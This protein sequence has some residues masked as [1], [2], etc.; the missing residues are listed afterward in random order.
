MAGGEI[1]GGGCLSFSCTTVP[2]RTALSW[3]HPAP[4]TPPS[5]VRVERLLKAFSRTL[6]SRLRVSAM[7]SPHKRLPDLHANMLGQLG[8]SRAG[9]SSAHVRVCPSQWRQL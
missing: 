8:R 2:G 7:R 1:A 6:C 9:W 5:L 4:S 3:R